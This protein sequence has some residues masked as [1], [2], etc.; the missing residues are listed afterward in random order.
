[1][2]LLLCF[3]GKC[4]IFAEKNFVSTKFNIKNGIYMSVSVKIRTNDVP[5]PDAISRRVE[6]RELKL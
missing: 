6:I 4:C 2:I 3:S 1:M 5:E